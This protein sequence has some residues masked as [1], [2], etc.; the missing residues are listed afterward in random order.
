MTA[1]GFH[2]TSTQQPHVGS[3]SVVQGAREK[4]GAG[5]DIAGG[6]KGN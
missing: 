3:S 1:G 5:D 6:N 2:P 4:E